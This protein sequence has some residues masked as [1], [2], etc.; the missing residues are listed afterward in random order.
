M[1][2]FTLSLSIISRDFIDSRVTLPIHIQLL[3]IFDTTLQEAIELLLC[4]ERGL[5]RRHYLFIV[6]L[7]VKKDT[8]HFSCNLVLRD[9]QRV[10]ASGFAEFR[11]VQWQKAGE[12]V[13][14]LRHA[15]C[16]RLIWCF[17]DSRSPQCNNQ[18]W[19]L[20]SS[21]RPLRNHVADLHGSDPGP[22]LD[23]R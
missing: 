17:S 1:I 11:S 18:L 22:V 8:D 5:H 12:I 20:R 16:Y 7:S 9:G 15:L 3:W 21:T 6:L 19:A 13:T 2:I 10:H 23:Y 4:D 14:L